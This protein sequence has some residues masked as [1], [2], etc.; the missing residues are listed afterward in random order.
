MPDYR[1]T[2][3]VRDVA[4]GDIFDLAQKIWDDHADDLDAKLGDFK[5]VVTKTVG[6]SSYLVDWHPGE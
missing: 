3:D 2:I 6:S 5:I 1:I 4:A